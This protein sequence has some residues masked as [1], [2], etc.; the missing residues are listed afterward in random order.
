MTLHS[1]VGT[2]TKVDRH[3]VLVE[4]E[5]RS[6]WIQKKVWDAKVGDKVRLAYEASK[7]YGFWHVLEVLS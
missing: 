5:G 3:T 7:S 2:V 6:E 4:G 1:F